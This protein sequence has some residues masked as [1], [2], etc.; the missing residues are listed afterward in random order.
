MDKY[1]HVEVVPYTAYQ[2]Q[3]SNA[4]T[5]LAWTLNALTQQSQL[6][7]IGMVPGTAVQKYG[8]AGRV[9]I[10]EAEAQSRQEILAPNEAH[11]AVR[12]T[13]IFSG[14][15]LQHAIGAVTVRRDPSVQLRD[16]GTTGAL[17]RTP[18]Y[19]LLPRAYFGIEIFTAS[20][21]DPAGTIT[22]EA[23]RQVTAGLIV[24]RE[25]GMYA[26][27]LLTEQQTEQMGEGLKQ[28]GLHKVAAIGH[29]A[30]GGARE[31]LWPVQQASELYANTVPG[32]G[33]AELARPFVQKA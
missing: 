12:I 9:G 27:T 5:Q 2:Q 4:L 14:A 16:E 6:Y 17:R 24:A 8:G 15:P 28:V 30:V 18:R 7:E 20:R 21:H 22:L 11:A 33:L 13:E 26:F 25:L 10:Q 23:L 1:P 32:T 29:Y 3:H 31:S 19:M